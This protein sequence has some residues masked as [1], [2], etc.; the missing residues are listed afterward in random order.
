MLTH[1]FLLQ[2]NQLYDTSACLPCQTECVGADKDPQVIPPQVLDL[3]NLPR[4][5]LTHVC[6][7]FSGHGPVCV[8][9]LRDEWS[10]LHLQAMQQLVPRGHLRIQPLQWEGR[11][12][13]GMLHLQE[14]LHRG[15]AWHLRRKR[16]VHS[17]GQV[18]WIGHVGRSGMSSLFHSLMLRCSDNSS[19]P[20]GSIGSP[21]S[22]ALVL[23]WWAVFHAS[24]M[25]CHKLVYLSPNELQLSA[26]ICKSVST[27]F[28]SLS[29]FF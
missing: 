13:H 22:S 14:L 16:T 27:I 5:T 2:G 25:S 8:Q 29:S 26:C 9:A 23:D 24:L 18:R 21:N 15:Q 19:I 12:R 11:H 28:V 7:P 3:I 1:D 6:N 20:Q 10:G 4:S 17:R